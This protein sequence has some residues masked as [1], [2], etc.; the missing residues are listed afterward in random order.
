MKY[1]VN[2]QATNISRFLPITGN[3]S[4][5]AVII[6]SDPPN[7]KKILQNVLFFLLNNF[8]FTKNNYRAVQA[9]RQQHHEEYQ[10]PEHGAGHSG[11]RRRINDEH[12][13]RSLGGDLLNG[14]STR[15]SHV[16][17]HGEYDKSSYE[18]RR[19]VNHAR[20]Q[21]VPVINKKEIK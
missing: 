16:A 14:F 20:E 21:G 3:S 5:R 18:G 2:R 7:Y 11:N 19:A 6:A 9:K 8:F 4:L 13:S 1:N 10:S 17:K 12:Q 15:M